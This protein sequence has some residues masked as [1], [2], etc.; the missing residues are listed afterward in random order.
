[1]AMYFRVL[2]CVILVALGCVCSYQL[3][4]NCRQRRSVCIGLTHRIPPGVNGIGQYRTILHSSM[5][6]ETQ[7]SNSRHSDHTIDYSA[8]EPNDPAFLDMPWPTESGPE[9]TAF[10]KHMLWRRS[11]S[12]GESKT[13][14]DG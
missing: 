6:G 13:K 12:S 2:L 8:L 3:S 14:V 9:A 7:I 1:M 5:E 4:R 11:L 10:A